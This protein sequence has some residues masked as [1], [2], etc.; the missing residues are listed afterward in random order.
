MKNN[1]KILLR[2]G[3]LFVCIG[4]LLAWCLIGSY[5]GVSYVKAVFPGDPQRILQAH[6]YFLYMGALTLGL[7]ATELPLYWHIKWSMVIGA[8]TFSGIFLVSAMF[9]ATDPRSDLYMP[10]LKINDIAHYLSRFSFIITT[11]GFGGAGI[12]LFRYTVSNK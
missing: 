11:Y 5:S 9:P 10:E 7:R 12:S 4:L 8:F 2:G 1:D 6:L 3:S